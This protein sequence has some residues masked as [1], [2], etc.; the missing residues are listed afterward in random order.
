MNSVSWFSSIIWH[1]HLNLDTDELKNF[2]LMKSK[3][4]PGRVR[5]N[6]GGWQGASE[7]FYHEDSI[8]QNVIL[9]VNEKI[10]Y[11]SEQLE[12]S[13][14]LHFANFWININKKGDS[15][16]KHCHPKSFLSAVFYVNAPEPSSDIVFYD[17]RPQRT[18]A[19]SDCFSRWN[20]L[21]ALSNGITPKTGLL[22]IFPSWL[23]HE[24]APHL[25]DEPRIS[26]A[27]NYRLNCVHE[28]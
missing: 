5:S 13:D 24:V 19:E 20:T 14:K 3:T 1:D 22:L 9:A 28:I 6:V 10:D 16:L 2:C 15:N 11:V 23:E 17:P 27:F 12:M 8:L 18:F 25:S 7:E 4:I 21:N 26:I